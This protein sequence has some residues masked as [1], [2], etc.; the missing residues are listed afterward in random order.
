MNDGRKSSES[1]TGLVLI[2]AA[3][4]RLYDVASCNCFIKDSLR[5]HVAD[6]TQNAPV[7]VRLASGVADANT[8]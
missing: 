1:A 8:G 4:T 7:G 2:E 5:I 6:M 3:R